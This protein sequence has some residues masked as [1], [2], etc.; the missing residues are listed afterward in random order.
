MVRL[1]AVTL[2]AVLAIAAGS[3]FSLPAMARGGMGHAGFGQAGGF[4]HAAF[5]HAGGFGHFIGRSSLCFPGSIC[6]PASI[7]RTGLRL[8]RRAL[9]LL[10]LLLCARMDRLGLALGERVLLKLAVT[11]T[12]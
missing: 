11:L 1:M 2:A 5:G 12:A 10:Q 9:R 3:T 8:R 7:L 6:L 4:G